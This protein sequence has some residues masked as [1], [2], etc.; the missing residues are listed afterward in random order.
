MILFGAFILLGTHAA[1]AQKVNPKKAP[2]TQTIR[3]GFTDA[4]GDGI[5]DRYDGTQPGKGLGPGN[6]QGQGCIAGKGPGKGLGLRDGSCIRQR[7]SDTS[8]TG[9]NRGNGRRL[10]DGSGVNCILPPK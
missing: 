3:S 1:E 6:G 4:N 8:G 2:S 9:R 7:R 10:R 5:C